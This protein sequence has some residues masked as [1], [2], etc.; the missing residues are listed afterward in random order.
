MVVLVALTEPHWVLKTI[1][2]WT[3][4][5]A[6]AA[7][8]D[9]ALDRER[10]WREAVEAVPP[11]LRTASA[12]VALRVIADLTVASVLTH[13]QHHLW[14]VAARANRA[15]SCSALG[16]AQ[17]VPCW[18]RLEE[19]AACW[20]VAVEAA[21]RQKPIAW[22]QALET[23]TFSIEDRRIRRDPIRPCHS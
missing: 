6:A 1:P 16:A 8:T 15:K 12:M 14:V 2:R 18:A 7:L 23:K 20:A 19:V 10:C 5:A 3:A 11:E 17:P 21:P 9:S 4:A 13:S 22:V